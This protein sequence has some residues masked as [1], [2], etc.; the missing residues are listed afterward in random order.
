M[1]GIDASPLTREEYD[2]FDVSVMKPSTKRMMASILS[3]IDVRDILQ[4]I[5][6]F[7]VLEKLGDKAFDANAYT[8]DMFRAFSEHR[9]AN[10]Q[11]TPNDVNLLMREIGCPEDMD[12]LQVLRAMCAVSVLLQ[13]NRVWQE[14]IDWFGD[15]QRRQLFNDPLSVLRHIHCHFVSKQIRRQD[16]QDK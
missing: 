11:R 16:K 6:F 15:D 13:S 3:R 7:D 8:E 12:Q 4:S 10:C 2:A 1:G 5:A 9:F 14:N